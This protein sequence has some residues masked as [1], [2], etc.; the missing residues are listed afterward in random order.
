MTK[1]MTKQLFLYVMSVG[2]LLSAPAALAAQTREAERQT[3]V[4]GTVEAVDHTNRT[5]TIRLKDGK[6]V[7]LD[8]PKEAMRFDEVKVGDGVMASYYNRVSLRLKPAG[9]AP[10][11]RVEERGRTAEQLLLLVGPELAD[12]LDVAT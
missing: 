4:Q 8:V 9:E 1:A 11:D 2:L 5:V 10:V 12:V 7:T 3:T 6:V